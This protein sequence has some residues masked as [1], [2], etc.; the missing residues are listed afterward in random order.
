MGCRTVEVGNVLDGKPLCYSSSLLI[1]PLEPLHA[2]SEVLDIIK[3]HLDKAS[4]RD[5]GNTM[6]NNLH[7]ELEALHTMQLHVLDSYL[8]H[9]VA[10]CC[11]AR[12]RGARQVQGLMNP[13]AQESDLLDPNC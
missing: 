5:N 8:N 13:R 7:E 2:G 3:S 10:C 9:L 4:Y 11:G 12:Q 1:P 6:I